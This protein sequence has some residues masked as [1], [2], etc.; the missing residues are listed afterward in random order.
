MAVEHQSVT[1]RT[2]AVGDIHGC[3][4]ALKAVL[5]MAA[6][7]PNDTFVFLGDYVDRGPHSSGVIETLIELGHQCRV[8]PLLG[9]H[10]LMLLAACLD[11]QERD[12]WL[13]CGG[14]ETLASYDGDL[15]KVPE[16]H[17]DYLAACLRHWETDSH[18]FVH[19][20][21]VPDL[22]LDQTGDYAL[23]WQ[24]LPKAVLLPHRSGK[25][26][27]CGHTPQIAGDILDLGYLICIDTFCAGGGWL[28][29]LDV[30]SRT[31]WQADAEGNPRE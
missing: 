28:T 23:F 2:I 30:R 6:P 13:T 20:C 19:A 21:Y 10:E 12:F 25:T 18:I 24:H 11:E 22:A 15:S 7:Q 27:V 9:N 17:I 8:V 14:R 1:G 29:A 3:H 26:V 5:N 16:R 31:L 4:A